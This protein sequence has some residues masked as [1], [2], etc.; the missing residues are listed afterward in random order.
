MAKAKGSTPMSEYEI[1][2]RNTRNHIRAMRS[3][4]A[5]TYLTA[6]LKKAKKAEVKKGLCEVRGDAYLGRGHLKD[7]AQAVSQYQK[8]NDLRGLVLAAEAYTSLGKGEKAKETYALAR[9][10]IKSNP[11]T[12]E[13]KAAYERLAVYSRE[14]KGAMYDAKQISGLLK[15]Y[16][17]Q[18]NKK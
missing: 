16:E 11:I 8:A 7:I 12:P 15:K 6:E 14:E 18:Y 2:V 13:N 3:D 10:L 5:M 9:S 1:T 17:A 4:D